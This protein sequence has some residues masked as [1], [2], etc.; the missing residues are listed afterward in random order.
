MTFLLFLFGIFLA[1]GMFLL[2]ADLL[3]LPRL[4]TQRAMLSVGRQEKKQARSVEALLMGWAIKLAP[5]IHMDEYK[6]GRLKNTLA[7]AGLNMTPEEY[8]AFA[9]VKTGAVLL[10]VIPC[11]L[12]FPM[13]ALIVV[14]LAVAV[15]FKE[16]RRAEEKLSA[17][18]DEIEAELPRF[19]ATITQ[20]L[21]ASRDVLSM[22]EHGKLNFYIPINFDPDAVFG[23]NV[24]SAFNDDWLNVYA[25]FGWKT[26]RIDSALTVCLVCSDGHEF[27]FFYPLT[28]AEQVQLWNQMDAYCHQQNGQ[29]LG[30]TRTALLREQAEEGLEIRL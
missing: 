7:A 28:S 30:E 9:M 6:R 17:K 16:I 19:V 20:E 13:L 27:E 4:A 18:R 14:L 25:N 21:A 11:L 22:I 23:T 5:H 15:Y 1:L 2:T 24:A 12:I 8:T 3:R 26:G 10:T 29:S